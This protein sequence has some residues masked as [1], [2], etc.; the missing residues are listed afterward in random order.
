MTKNQKRKKRSAGSNSPFRMSTK[1]RTPF[2][3]FCT[4]PVYGRMP[5]PLLFFR[6]PFRPPDDL[7]S[8]EHIGTDPTPE[9]LAQVSSPR[10]RALDLDDGLRDADQK[11]SRVALFDV[12]R[13]EKQLY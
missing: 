3:S 8:L 4:R 11:G 1:D 6:R 10:L 9:L 7:A 13:G 5:L 2:P 12:C